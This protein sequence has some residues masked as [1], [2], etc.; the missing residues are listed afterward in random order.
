MSISCEKQPSDKYKI[1]RSSKYKK[2][3]LETRKDIGFQMF[4]SDIP[5]LS[6]AVYLNNE[7]VWSE[8]LGYASKELNVPVRPNTK[9]RIGGVSKLFT[10]VLLARMVENGELDLKT[11]L[12]QY[13]P[14]LPEDKDSVSLYHL[15][16]HSSGIRTPTFNETTNQGY[17]T[18]RKGISVFI[19]DS[20]LFQPGQ[21]YYETDYGY[22]LIG[23]AIERKTESLF[24]KI[25]KEKLTDTLKLETTEAD[26]PIAVIENRSQCYDRNLIARTIRS[27][28]QDNRHRAASV[29]LLSSAVDIAT[30][31]NEFLH[32]TV[33]KEETVK[34]IISPMTLT[35]GGQLN[36]GLGL[37]IGQ[38]NQGR[39]L[40]MSSGSTKG[41]SA[42]VIA[43]PKLDLVVAA[44]C[45]QGQEEEGLPVFKIASKFIELL[46]PQPQKE[47]PKQ[48]EK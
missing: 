46:E 38:D 15:A 14:E 37:Y 10:G 34:N 25:L 32:P 30:L 3:I 5:G 35:N 6:V 45:N 11:P 26:N 31:M 13:Y 2:I 47:Q 43:Y 28:T 41:G 44:A 1:I 7:L 23:A 21:F 22:D 42:A 33:L 29:G 40:Y 39:E 16:S 27:T 4:T 18:M 8:G 17:Q 36:S 24:H 9:F 19:E 12:R 48:P 20:L